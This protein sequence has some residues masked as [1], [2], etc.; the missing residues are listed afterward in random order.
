MEKVDFHHL[1]L[2]YF[3]LEGS[4]SE[5]EN[6]DAVCSDPAQEE[7]QNLPMTVDKRNI[8]VDQGSDSENDDEESKAATS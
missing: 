5:Q 1:D 2:E 3:C 6:E 7:Q 8:Q 4:L